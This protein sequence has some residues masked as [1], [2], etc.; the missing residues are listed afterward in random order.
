MSKIFEALKKAESVRAKRQS[1][2]PTG[3]SNVEE[4]DRRRTGRVKIQVPLVVYGYAPDGLLFCEEANTIAINAQ[5]GSVSMLTVVRPGQKL[6][7]VNRVADQR[8][9]CV[10]I[11]VRARRAHGNEVAFEFPTSMPQFWRN[12]DKQKP[13]R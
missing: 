10:V 12:L 5:G 9:E 11:S 7:V 13:R 6:I 4:P 1:I 3:T 8:Q 2:R